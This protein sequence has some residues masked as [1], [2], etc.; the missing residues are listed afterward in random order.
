MWEEVG[1]EG[2]GKA[3][4][5]FPT[6]LTEECSHSLTRLYGGGACFPLTSL[7]L[8]G[9]RCVLASEIT[10]QEFAHH[11]P[12]Y[13]GAS[14]NFPLVSFVHLCVVVLNEGRR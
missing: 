1:I 2:G 14:E 3:D 9:S 12:R 13:V 4:S 5:T 7:Q 11:S 10:D 6:L 8:S